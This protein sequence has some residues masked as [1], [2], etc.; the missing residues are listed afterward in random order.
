M[1]ED[2]LFAERIKNKRENIQRR[3]VFSETV[4]GFSLSRLSQG[5]K[6]KRTKS[7]TDSSANIN[8]LNNIQNEYAK[9]FNIS[10]YYRVSDINNVDIR[11]INKEVNLPWKAIKEI[12]KISHRKRQNLLP[13]KD[14]AVEKIDSERATLRL[15][16]NKLWKSL[17]LLEYSIRRKCDQRVQNIM[18][19]VSKPSRKSLINN[20]YDSKRKAKSY[21]GKISDFTNSSEG[22]VK[23]IISGRVEQGLSEKER[24][25]ILERDNFKCQNCLSEDKLEVHHIIPVS[26]GGTK[27]QDNLCTLCF[28][29]HINIAHGTSTS[30]ISYDNKEQFWEIIS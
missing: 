17:Y 10:G 30:E 21:S 22:Y 6:I 2:Y 20:M 25:K 16:R 18:D 3:L 1:L 27:K 23:D 24:R 29:C 9:E 11:V 8:E 14:E 26:K 13:K 28:D 5:E 19:S 12:N 4:I 7:Q 15:T